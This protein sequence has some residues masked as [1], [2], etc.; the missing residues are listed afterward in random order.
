MAM[1]TGI[2][3]SLAAIAFASSAFADDA[4]DVDYLADVINQRLE[5]QRSGVEVPWMNPATG[6][7]GIIIITGTDMRDPSEPCRTYRRTT[8]RLSGDTTVVEGRACR[9]GDGLWQR[10]ESAAS[11]TPSPDPAPVARAEPEPVEP[12]PLIP[13]PGRKPDPDIF[14]ASVPTPSVY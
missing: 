13:P 8:E 14:F 10:T 6:N 7:R 9:V 3:L 4:R 2:A 1:R 11:A 5:T 12:P